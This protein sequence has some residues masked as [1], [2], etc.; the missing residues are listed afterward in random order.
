LTK[1][2]SWTILRSAISSQAWLVPRWPSLPFARHKTS[3]GSIRIS[4][5]S[6]KP[7]VPE[8][9]HSLRSFDLCHRT[10][11]AQELENELIHIQ[12]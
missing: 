8:R 3:L 1:V 4:H 12:E 2:L 9:R 6:A 7:L 10:E 11:L 5:T